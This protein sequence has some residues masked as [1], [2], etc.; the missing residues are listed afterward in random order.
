MDTYERINH[1]LSNACGAKREKIINRA[2]SVNGF[3]L[4]RLRDALM[5]MGRIHSEDLEN[6]T[7]VA[8]LP[9]GIR[10]RNRAVVAFE[11]SEKKLLI[12]AYAEEGLIKQH[13]V[14]GVINEFEDSIKR[15]I[16]SDNN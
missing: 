2:Y 10:K 13:T 12:A 9:G 7:Y 6:H 11:L 8:V 4:I 15:F 16:V 5:K 3:S 14:E 1:V